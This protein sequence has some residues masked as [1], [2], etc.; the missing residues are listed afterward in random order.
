MRHAVLFFVFFSLFAASFS[1]NCFNASTQRS[2]WPYLSASAQYGHFSTILSGAI[3]LL[4]SI[5]RPA[6]NSRR[7]SIALVF[8]IYQVGLM[9][10]ID[11][12]SAFATLNIRSFNSDHFWV[13]PD[14]I[15]E[16]SCEVIALTETWLTA[17]HTPAEL[18]DLAP[19]GHDLLS[20]HRIS[21]IGGGVP[22][23]V[24][25]DLNYSFD[26]FTFSS[27]EAISISASQSNC[28]PLLSPYLIS[29]G[30]PTL[31]NTVSLS[32]SS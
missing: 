20:C 9:L 29:T 31:P 8:S 28:R 27:F 11:Q 5:S 19:A 32:I 17:S 16:Q 23:R 21:G 13:R 6:F 24:H 26:Q 2:A 15:Q 30:H 18:I 14:I 3:C 22:F 7:H 4:R 12:L 1:T 25:Q 10:T